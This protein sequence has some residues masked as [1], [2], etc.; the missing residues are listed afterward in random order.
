MTKSRFPDSLVLILAMVVLAQ[1]ATLVLPAGR[2][3]EVEN[4]KGRMEVVA[5]TFERIEPEQSGEDTG[6]LESP[7]GQW[8]WAVPNALLSIP[9][10]LDEGADV[11]FFVFLIGGV[12][13]ILRRT[14]AIDAV[15]GVALGRF[16]GQPVLLVA[17]MTTLFAIGSSLIGM[18]EEYMPFIPI[19][20]TMC[21][22]MRMDAV[23]ALG[24][25]YIGA[26]VGYGCAAF[27]PFTVQIGQEIA[28]LP[29]TSGQG[30][31]WVLLGVCLVVGVHHIMGYAKRI[32]RDPSRSLVHD[33]DYSTGFEMP[34][35]TTMTGRRL[36]ILLLFAATIGVFVWGAQVHD[37]FLTELSALFL[38]LGLVVTIVAGLSPNTASRE[39]CKG[40]GEMTTTALLIGFAR[41]IQVVLDE[42]NITHTLVHAVEAPLQAIGPNGA[43]VGMFL[44]QSLCNLFVP[45]G[46][47]Q[48]YVTM[49]IMV[50]IADVVEVSRQT[51]VLAYQLGDGFTN[52]IVPTNAL[53]MGMLGLARIPYERWV[54]FI[55]PLLVKLFVVAA[56]ALWIAVSIEYGPS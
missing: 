6:F 48:A 55:L 11:I 17:G 38:G 18:A 10:G 39:F 50:P 29:K 49:P 23:V 5:G 2:Y 24:I 31:R 35:Q 41:T 36:A 51:S 15:I 47:G 14:G 9:S 42:G 7:A 34:E 16:E 37:W 52:M 4:E 53:L 33:L 28:Q 3:Q 54:K 25:V 1:L 32:E 22:A 21:L 56:V 43:A 19:L 12:I 30:F 45:S 13:G 44:V 46:S 40:A 20:V 8:V 27:N 26:G